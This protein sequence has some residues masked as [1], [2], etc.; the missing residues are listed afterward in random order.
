M[1]TV[2]MLQKAC[3]A[4]GITMAELFAENEL[5]ELSPEVKALYDDWR[6][7]TKDEQAS[8]KQIVN[9]YIKSKQK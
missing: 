2:P 6:C 1:P 5:V 4:L 9:N 3:D 7:L 8:I